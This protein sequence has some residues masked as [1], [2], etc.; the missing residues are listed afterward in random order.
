M[1]T[2]MCA[3]ECASMYEVC[4]HVS[5]LH[6]YICVHVHVCM[7][8]FMY[9]CMFVYVQIC[10]YLR[11]MSCHVMGAFHPGLGQSS[12]VQR[13]AVCACLQQ[14]RYH[15]TWCRSIFVFGVRVLVM[16]VGYVDSCCRR[17][18][19]QENHVD[20]SQ[21]VDGEKT[22]TSYHLHMQR[23]PSTLGVAPITKLSRISTLHFVLPKRGTIKLLFTV[24]C[25]QGHAPHDQ[26]ACTPWSC[27]RS[28]CGVSCGA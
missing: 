7:C 6:M 23:I 13:V 26:G 8:V 28:Q 15:S 22:S 17:C 18:A 16:L 14:N 3:C 5:D 1:C 27:E 19:V 10:K 24:E 2:W 4:V 9:A 20:P 11:A 12:S 21:L 25:T